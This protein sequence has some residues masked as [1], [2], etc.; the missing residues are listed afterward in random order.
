VDNGD[1]TTIPGADPLTRFWTDM[2]GRMAAT[3]MSAPPASRD[4]FEQMRSAFLDVLSKHTDD[5]LRSE[6]FLSALKQ[7]MDSGLA[8]RR[9]MNE[10]LTRSLETLQMPT[11]TDVEEVIQLVR[12]MEQRIGRRLDEFDERLARLE[13]SSNGGSGQRVDHSATE[14]S[15]AKDHPTPTKPPGARSRRNRR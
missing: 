2:L 13:A 6:Q 3:G 8:F 15:A 10:M 14:R 7:S 12:N 1:T 4:M 9:Q 11:S 5:F